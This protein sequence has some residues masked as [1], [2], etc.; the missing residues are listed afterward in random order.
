MARKVTRTESVKSHKAFGL[1]RVNQYTLLKKVG[2]GAFGEV[3]MAIEPAKNPEDDDPTYA[4]KI[5]NK[6]K[7]PGASDGDFSR[8]NELTAL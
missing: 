3:H 5:I 7:I 2:M 8:L 1:Q 6:S 4:V